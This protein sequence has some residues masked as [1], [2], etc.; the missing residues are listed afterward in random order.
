ML[1]GKKILLGITG[2]IAAYK[3]AFLARLLVKEGA[4]VQV[5]LTPGALDFITPLTLSALTGRPVYV[6][7]HDTTTG[8]WYNHVE[9]GLWADAMVIAPATTNTLAKMAHGHCDNFLLACYLSARCPV[10]FAPAMDLDMYAHPAVQ[11]SIQTLQTFG[12]HL[13][14]SESGPL[15]SGLSGKGRMAEPETILAH[16]QDYFRKRTSLSGKTVLINGGPTYEHIDPVRFI[17]NHSSGDTAVYLAREAHSRGARVTLV[18]GPTRY[19]SH[20]FPFEV[21]H[22]TSALQMHTECLARAASADV[23]ICAAAVADYRPAEYQINKIKKNQDS[24]S[25]QLVKNPD[26]LADLCQSKKAHQH[27]IGFALETENLTQNALTK[28]HQKKADAIIANSPGP[29]TGFATPTN[30][31]TILYS[32]GTIHQSSLVLKN[33]LA[34]WIWDHISEHFQISQ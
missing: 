27:I 10:F 28:L 14:D 13:I 5:V 30:Q 34:S 18:L 12:C 16:L 25:I 32:D 6:H 29:H 1:S 23:I 26:I 9:L 8:Q 31:V 17:G 22:V 11:H 21:V 4:D 33:K 7:S 20:T 15:A 3:S 19:T 24:L 2:G